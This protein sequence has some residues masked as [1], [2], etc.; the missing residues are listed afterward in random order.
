MGSEKLSK[1]QNIMLVLMRAIMTPHITEESFGNFILDDL[2]AQM[3]Y[4]VLRDPEI[5]PC[6]PATERS[7]FAQPLLP[8][9][10]KTALYKL[11]PGIPR[12]E[13]L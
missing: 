1:E 2:P 9:C 4:S 7:S 13:L 10:L 5:N 3:G 11:N 6:E 12:E 8:S